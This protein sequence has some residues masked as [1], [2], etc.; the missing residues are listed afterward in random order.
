M[1]II[2]TIHYTVTKPTSFTK[3]AT[4]NDS[5]REEITI[6]KYQISTMKIIKLFPIKFFVYIKLSLI[7]NFI[8]LRKEAISDHWSIQWVIQRN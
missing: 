2:I 7:G 1:L 8:I 4:L 5:K 6:D 3:N